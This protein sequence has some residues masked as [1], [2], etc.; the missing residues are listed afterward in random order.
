MAGESMLLTR[1]AGFLRAADR[2]LDWLF[3]RRCIG[4]GGE[5]D[6]LCA[7]CAAALPAL[8][9]PLCPRCGFPLA[10]C[11]L[12]PDCSH[13]PLAIDGIRSPY[14]HKGL[15]RELVH[16]LKY[17]HFKA[18]AGPAA[19]LMARYF[20]AHPLP[21]DLLIAV[22]IHS[23]RLRR[24]GYNQADL[25]ARKLSRFIGVPIVGE[26]VL[27]RIRDTDS[28]VGLGAQARRHNVAGAF[29]CRQGVLT[30]KRILLIDDVCTTGA[31]LS[32]CAVALKEAGAVSVWGFTFSREC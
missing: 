9:P 27:V 8:H 19:R 4:C 7:R 22:P 32:A 25:M 21:A 1:S 14:L 28:Q 30:G 5:G 11:T 31:T 12:C 23:K 6:F 2:L 13:L 29:A 17:D 26:G 16:S 3:P 24:R 18:L 10:S 20:E 15:A